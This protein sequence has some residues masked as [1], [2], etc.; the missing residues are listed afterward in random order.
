MPRTNKNICLYCFGDLDDHRVC[1]SCRRPADDT[2]VP[3]THLPQRSVLGDEHKYLF[4]KALGQGGFGITY[5]GW[6][7]ALGRRVAI[8]EYFPS[9]YVTRM[10]GTNNVVII[11]PQFAEASNRGLR[12]FIEEAR[13][14]A[15]VKNLPGIVSVYDFFSANGTAY[16]VMEY[17]DGLS[18][19]KYI[20]R[21]GGM[22]SVDSALAILRPVMESLAE[23][24]KMG[25]VHRDISPDNIIITRK[26]EVKLIDFGAAKQSNAD[27]KALS[28]ILKQGFAPPE[29]YTPTAPQGAWT[30]I[31]ALAVTIY[32]AITGVIPPESITR[33]TKDTLVP[34]S[35][36]GIHIAPVVEFAL[37]K[38]LAVEVKDRYHDL[39][40]LVSALYP[41]NV[42]VRPPSAFPSTTAFDDFRT[43]EYAAAIPRTAKL[44]T[45]DA[46][47]RVITTPHASAMRPTQSVSPAQTAQTPPPPPKPMSEGAKETL[48]QIG[49][50]HD[51][52]EKL[53]TAQAPVVTNITNILPDLDT[54]IAQQQSREPTPP[55]DKKTLKQMKK[56]EKKNKKD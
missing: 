4:G 32:Y 6:D 12:R 14:L 40:D 25:L 49:D 42:P 44:N 2:R 9:H 27:G 46:A 38:A 31:Y 48:S 10:L 45:V 52:R 8:K 37:M 20:H 39:S 54:I 30:D 23:V 41:Q 13:I 26:N 5:F 36:L 34:P 11:A 56:E 18:L 3:A 1:K 15:K 24:H 50:V 16:I 21:K 29:Q 53:L 51:F 19:K 43:E 55:P 22:I 33:K 7:L 17:L 35:K 47:T 28:V